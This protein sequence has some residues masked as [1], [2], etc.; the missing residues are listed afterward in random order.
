MTMQQL[1]V[2]DACDTTLDRDRSRVALKVAAAGTSVASGITAGG[3][4]GAS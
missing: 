4:G 2:V 3:G 1:F